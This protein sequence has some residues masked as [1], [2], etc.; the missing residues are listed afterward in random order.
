MQCVTE[1]FTSTCPSIWTNKLKL[2][3]P[4]WNYIAK[5]RFATKQNL[6]IDDKLGNFF[7]ISDIFLYF[8]LVC[9]GW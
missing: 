3:L 2:Y 6:K 1:E 9:V 4:D 5:L 7:C 8:Q